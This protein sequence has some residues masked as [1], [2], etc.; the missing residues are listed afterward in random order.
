MSDW[1]WSVEERGRLAAFLEKRGL[2]SGEVT[3]QRIGDGHS[4]LTYLVSDSTGRQVVV[5]RPPPPPTPPGAHDMLR[6]ARLVG[7]LAGTPVPVA[8][9]LATAEADEVIDVHFYVMSFAAGPV[10]TTE[11]PAPLDTPEVRRRI[12]ET[13]V[14][15]L[16]DLHAVDWRAAGLTDI[17]KPEGFNARHL[18][19]MARLVAD[20][21]GKPPPHFAEIDAWLQVHVPAESGAAIVHN[22]F[23]IGNVVLDADRPGE[24]KA[25]LDWELATIGDPLFDLGYFL[26]SVPDPEEPLTPTEELGTAMLEDGYPTRKELAARYADRTGADLGELDWYTALALWKLAVLYEYGRRRAARGVGDD[27]YADQALVQSFLDAAHHTAGLPPAP[28]PPED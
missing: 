25:V 12:G 1:D 13:L 4:N 3:T 19:R 15:T 26:S 7:A 18:K 28:A 9:V 22:D 20:D 6:E 8:D 14:D 23:R 5:R 16:A 24:I 10:V 21:D 17:G 2:T 11:S 27:Y